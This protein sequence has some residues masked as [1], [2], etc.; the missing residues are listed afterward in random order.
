MRIVGLQHYEAVDAYSAGVLRTNA[1]VFIERVSSGTKRRG[2]NSWSYRVYCGSYHIGYLPDFIGRLVAISG[3]QKWYQA[4]VC[5]VRQK[6]SRATGRSVLEVDTCFQTGLTK[7]PDGYMLCKGSPR[8]PGIYGIVNMSDMR[9]YIGR[10]TDLSRRKSEHRV[11][12]EKGAHFKTALQ[13]E[14]DEN[15]E[16]LAFI[17]ID[18]DP[19]DLEYQEQY[20]VFLY[21]TK[22]EVNGFNFGVGFS[23]GSSQ[24]SKKKSSRRPGHFPINSSRATIDPRFPPFPNRKTIRSVCEFLEKIGMRAVNNRPK[25]GGLWVLR[26]HHEFHKVAD[27]LT[28][29]GIEVKRYPEGRKRCRK[30]HYGIDPRKCLPEY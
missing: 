14:Y 6:K 5:D 1:Q 15:A 22:D 29:V 12:F 19:D 23:P 9:T 10:S 17:V 11:A 24:K 3:S 20:R 21:G 25:G 18:K 30:D 8:V 28:R 2:E 13:A 16:Q 26:S 7:A 27:Y 4:R